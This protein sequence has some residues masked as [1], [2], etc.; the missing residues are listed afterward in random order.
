MVAGIATS[1]ALKTGTYGLTSAGQQRHVTRE[2]HALGSITSLGQSL[3]RSLK[4]YKRMLPLGFGACI[5]LSDESL[6]Q[7]GEHRAVGRGAG[8]P[9]AAMDSEKVGSVTFRAPF[10]L[11]SS[12]L[13]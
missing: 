10:L 12:A 2:L 9:H 7:G 5:V 6:R 3:Q 4:L 8:R 13:G 1:P 11:L